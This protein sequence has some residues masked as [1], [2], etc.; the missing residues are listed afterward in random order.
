MK[1]AAKPAS[2]VVRAT[3]LTALKD[4]ISK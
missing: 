1:I 4:T 3:A 2:T